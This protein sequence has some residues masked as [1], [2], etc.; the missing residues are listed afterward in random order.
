M[1]VSKWGDQ[2][3]FRPYF[4]REK[5]KLDSSGAR[6]RD[7][8]TCTRTRGKRYDTTTFAVRNTR[9]P[10]FGIKEINTEHRPFRTPFT[11][12]PTNMQLRDPDTIVKRILPC[13]VFGM[14]SET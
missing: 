3:G 7:A 14:V 5:E 9:G 10:R 12:V 2:W 4:T 8:R 1:P 6:T 13:E 11:V